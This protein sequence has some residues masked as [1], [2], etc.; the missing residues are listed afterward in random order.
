L[1]RQHLLSLVCFLILMMLSCD[2]SVATGEKKMDP[3]RFET[4]GSRTS[5]S[6]EYS[7]VSKDTVIIIVDENAIATLSSTGPVYVD[8]INCVLDPSGFTDTYNITGLADP[9]TKMISFSSC[10]DGGFLG[11]GDVS[12]MS[13]RP[14]GE[15]SCTYMK[16]DDK[17]KMRMHLWVPAE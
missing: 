7:C 4:D 16:G 15:V 11:S 9:E 6:G 1:K 12:Y 8:Y 2:Y 10:N 3:L 13:G 5:F 14:M 17:G